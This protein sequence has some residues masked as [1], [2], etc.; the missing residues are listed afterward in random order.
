MPQDPPRA[1]ASK[2]RAAS[3]GRGLRPRLPE[4]GTMRVLRTL[5]RGNAFGAL[6]GASETQKLK[7][8]GTLCSQGPAVFCVLQPPDGGLHPLPRY[9]DVLPVPGHPP[10]G[11]FLP[12][13][14]WSR[15]AE[16][17]SE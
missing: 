9:Q 16:C 2:L 11:K 12:L 7:N 1:D 17:P 6:P 5:R 15:F 13:L 4:A 8:G 14:F 3:G 10:A